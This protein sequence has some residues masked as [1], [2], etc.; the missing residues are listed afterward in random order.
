[1]RKKKAFYNRNSW[2]TFCSLFERKLWKTWHFLKIQQSSKRRQKMYKISFFLLWIGNF[3]RLYCQRS[4]KNEYEPINRLHSTT[5]W[6]AFC[7]RLRY[8][9]QTLDL[10]LLWIIIG[11][12]ITIINSYVFPSCGIWKTYKIECEWNAG[13]HIK[14]N[15]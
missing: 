15:A 1:M 3:S 5:A 7:V 9:K 13:N 10:T 14:R 11:N 2:D 4:G 6:W 8:D 12:G